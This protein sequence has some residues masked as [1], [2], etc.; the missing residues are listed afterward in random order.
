MQHEN[1]AIWRAKM[2]DELDLATAATNPSEAERHSAR[3]KVFEGY[4][5]A[6]IPP[7][8]PDDLDIP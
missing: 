5:D 4:A 7:D 3:A 2:Q 6:D 1:K 8:A